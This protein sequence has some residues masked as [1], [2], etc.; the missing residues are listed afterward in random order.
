MNFIS[1]LFKSSPGVSFS[2]YPHLL[3]LAA[4]LIIGSIVF[5]FIYKKKKKTDV[6]FKKAFQDVSKRS[7]IMGIL[8]LALVAVRYQNIPYF[9]M[10]LW[11][12]IA[13]AMVI[14]YVYKYVKIYTKDYKET[15][16]RMHEKQVHTTKQEKQYLPHKKRR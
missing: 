6:A 15:K 1:S 9:S 7:C 11:L 8:F 13:V 16:A 4:L 5:H 12:Y 2:Y 14:F 10:R 3:T